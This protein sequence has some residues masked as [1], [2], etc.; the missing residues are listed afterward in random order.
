VQ[1]ELNQASHGSVS[2]LSSGGWTLVWG[3]MSA[4]A[5]VGRRCDEEPHD[6]AQGPMTLRLA[7]SGSEVARGLARP[8][9]S[10]TRKAGDFPARKDQPSVLRVTRRLQIHCLQRDSVLLR[11]QFRPG[12]LPGT[13]GPSGSTNQRSVGVIRPLDPRLSVIALWSLSETR[14]LRHP[15]PTTSAC[16]RADHV[17]SAGAL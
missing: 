1:P 11:A 15:P 10:R 17:P 8:G 7:C 6:E 9:R 12:T 14:C 5:D 2:R 13:D 4:P 16:V 3:R